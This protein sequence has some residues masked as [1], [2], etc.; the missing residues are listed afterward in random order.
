MTGT[1]PSEWYLRMLLCPW[2]VRKATAHVDKK[3]LNTCH[4]SQKVFCGIFVGIPQN[5]KIYL[6]LVPSTRKIISSYDF[7]FDDIFSSMLAYTSQPYAESM[8]M[9]P[10]VSYI[11]CATYLRGGG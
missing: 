11:P 1:K 4:Q 7:V 8:A 6:V 3:S 5:Q 10:A 9:S 2:V